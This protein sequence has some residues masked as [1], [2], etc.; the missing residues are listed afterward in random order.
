MPN[1]ARRKVISQLMLMS[2]GLCALLAI[3]A[4]AIILA[5]ILVGGLRALSWDFL[6]NIPKPIGEPHSGIANAIVGS[7]ILIALG[8]LL[9]LPIGILAGIYLAEFGR[10]KFGYVLRFF[11]DTLIGVPSIVVGVFV[12]TVM[13]RPMGHFSAWAG[14]AALGLMMTPIM[15]RTTEEMIRLVPQNL[16]AAALALGAP[17]WRVSLG[18]VL[19]SAAPGVAT[20]GML[21]IARVAGET[22]PLLFTALALNYLSTDLNQPM[23]SLTFQIYYYAA[24][25]YDEWHAMAWAASLVLVTMILA[26]NVAVRFLARNRYES[27]G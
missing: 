25:P 26:L 16:R 10:N 27:A 3:G 9:G 20:G 21:A 17:V 14:G 12:W 18:V 19:R 15:A 8:S 23:A 7:L 13:V 1:A 24:S 22:A 2:T 5:Y 11:I 4:L 6:V